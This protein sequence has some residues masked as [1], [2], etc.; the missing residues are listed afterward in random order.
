[1]FRFPVL[2]EQGYGPVFQAACVTSLH[3]SRYFYVAEMT[4]VVEFAVSFLLEV[5]STGLVT[6]MLG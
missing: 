6:F 1:M 3:A 4:C 2:H 5:I